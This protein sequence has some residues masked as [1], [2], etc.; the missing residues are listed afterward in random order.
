MFAVNVTRVGGDAGYVVIGTGRADTVYALT[1]NGR[2]AVA[3]L[4]S[5]FDLL[6]P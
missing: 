5:G 3:N 6:N 4:D 2:T 1:D